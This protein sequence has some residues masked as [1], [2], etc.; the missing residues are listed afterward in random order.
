MGVSVLTAADSVQRLQPDW[1]EGWPPLCSQGLKGM[2]EEP[3]CPWEGH[4]A[5]G[6]KATGC[7]VGRILPS[8]K[9][10][11]TSGL[12]LFGGTELSG[13]PSAR[14]KVCLLPWFSQL[15]PTLGSR[16]GWG[17]TEALWTRVDGCGP[18]LKDGRME[19]PRQHEGHSWRTAVLPLEGVT[20]GARACQGPGL[21]CF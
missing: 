4:G 10:R 8:V 7:C 2:C 15:L 13:G 16:W 11:L 18:L 3:R 17:W 5:G 12:E 19:A 1:E 9:T 14:L 20:I 21:S 6:Y